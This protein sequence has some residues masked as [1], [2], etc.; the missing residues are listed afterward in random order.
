L[1]AVSAL[2]VIAEERV[3]AVIRAERID[4]SDA[5]AETFSRA[6]IKSIEITLTATNAAAAIEQLAR[7]SACVVGAGTVTNDHEA[8]LAI[9]SGAAF[10]VTPSSAPDVIR[11]GLAADVPV[12]GGAFTPTEVKGVAEQGAAA[13]KVFPARIGGPHYISD[14]LGPFPHLRLVPSGGVDDSNAA[15]YLAAG[16]FAVSTGSSV[17]PS[18]SVLSGDW[19]DI[20]QRA[21]AFVA[22]IPDSRPGRSE[23][24]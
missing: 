8:R 6:G 5:L 18:T 16:A 21:R 24:A 15:A 1:P 7:N 22:A 17:A 12:F 10:L 19:R 14:L 20:E 9:E 4:D 3:V 13:V 2:E 23:E 11:A